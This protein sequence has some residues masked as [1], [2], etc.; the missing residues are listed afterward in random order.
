MEE[1]LERHALLLG[2]LLFERE[3]LLVL[4]SHL[5]HLARGLL[6]R[7]LADG[8]L[9][10]LLQ[11]VLLLEGRR[12]YR[13]RHGVGLRPLDLHDAGRLLDYLHLVG[14]VGSN[15]LGLDN[16]HLAFIKGA[17]RSIG[18]RVCWRRSSEEWL[19]HVGNL[20]GLRLRLCWWQLGEDARLALVWHGVERNLIQLV[21][22][23]LLIS[24]RLLILGRD[25]LPI[26]LMLLLIVVTV[27]LP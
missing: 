18:V 24:L 11:L 6:H 14:P 7:S 25:P 16:G 9:N 13:L 21:L 8:R 20:D 19:L 10:L 5:R 23:L 15:M 17:G 22:E 27:L 26:P 1:P 12:Y 2:S 3:R 4:L